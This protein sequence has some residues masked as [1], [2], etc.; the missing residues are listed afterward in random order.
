MADSDP[1][2]VRSN[3]LDQVCPLGAVE[4]PKAIGG[5]VGQRRRREAK[6]G[7]EEND[8]VL[9][10]ARAT[11]IFARSTRDFVEVLQSTRGKDPTVLILIPMVGR[12]SGTDLAE[13]RLP[14]RS[15]SRRLTGAWQ[16]FQLHRRDAFEV[17][18][19]LNGFKTQ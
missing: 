18:R 7:M 3:S 5:G 4:L 10:L 14:A 13:I 11:R 16:C 6:F 19:R 15:R 8:P 1:W 2:L 12:G 9:G 17:R